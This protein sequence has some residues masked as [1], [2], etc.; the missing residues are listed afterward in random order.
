LAKIPSIPTKLWRT[1]AL[2]NI[3]PEIS[4]F[5]VFRDWIQVA[6]YAYICIALVVLVYVG[7]ETV[8]R[9]EGRKK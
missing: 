4:S 6:T 1:V 5:L 9:R 2:I 8:F 3:I 7:E